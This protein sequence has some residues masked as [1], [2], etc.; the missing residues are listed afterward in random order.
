MKQQFPDIHQQGSRGQWSQR[1]GKQMRWTPGSLQLSAWRHLLTQTLR[2]ESKHKTPKQEA[3]VLLRWRDT[4]TRTLGGSA[5]E[6]RHS[7]QLLREKAP[8]G[9]HK[10]VILLRP[11]KQLQGSCGLR[12]AQRSGRAGSFAEPEWRSFTERIQSIHGRDPSRARVGLKA[13]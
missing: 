3:Q 12:K 7:K 5:A 6:D 11:N 10:R 9:A 4:E 1:E 8:E 2:E 13:P